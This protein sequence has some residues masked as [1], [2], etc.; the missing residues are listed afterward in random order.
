MQAP[1]RR[2]AVTAVAVGLGADDDHTVDPAADDRLG[3]VVAVGEAA[4]REEEQIVVGVFERPAQP[5]QDR[6]VERVALHLAGAE[7]DRAHGGGA[8]AGQRPGGVVGPVAGL[9]YNAKD[10]IAG[11]GVDARA[12]A[13][14]ERDGVA[15][16][17]REAG[18]LFEGAGTRRRRRRITMSVHSAPRIACDPA[19]DNTPTP[20]PIG[21][22]GAG[23]GRPHSPCVVGRLGA[24]PTSATS[25]GDSTSRGEPISTARSSQRGSGVQLASSTGASLRDHNRQWMISVACWRTDGGTVSPSVR[26]VAILT[27]RSNEVA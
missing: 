18:D 23:A 16:D 5:A 9:A 17:P 8:A 19:P 22:G 27:K 3:E 12:E 4:R 20:L 25:A 10:A 2:A 14:R 11:L 1:W 7:A 24:R 6:I 26:A 15:R 21:A 13:D